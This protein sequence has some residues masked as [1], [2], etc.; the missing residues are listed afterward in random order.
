M[1]FCVLLLL[2][3]VVIFL[4][5]M[6]PNYSAEMLSGVPK[7]KTAVMCLVGE[8]RVLNKLHSGMSYSALGCEFNVNEKNIIY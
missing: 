5:K 2:V 8:I 6:A 3:A 7:H 1:Q 4:L